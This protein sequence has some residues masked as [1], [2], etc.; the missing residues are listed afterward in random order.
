MVGRWRLEVS[1]TTPRGRGALPCIVWPMTPKPPGLLVRYL[2]QSRC[3]VFVGAGMSVGAGLPTWRALLLEVISELVSSMP[4]GDVHQA[5]LKKLVDQGKLLEV[6][7]FCKEQLGAAYHQF[8]TERLRGDTAKLPATHQELMHLPFSAW[9]TTNYDKLLERAYSEIKGGFPKT[10]THRDT[11][12][13]GRLLF[14]SGPFI[15]K[16]HGDIDRPETVV[17]TSRDY[18][19]IIHANP[20]FNE[21]FTGLLLTKALFFVG[22][23]LSD[24]DFRLLMDRQLTHFRGFVP[25]RFALMTDMGPVERDVLWRTARIQVIPYVNS[26]GRHEE[27]LH[28]L[29]ALNAAVKPEPAPTKA[30]PPPP[31]ASSFNTASPS[32]VQVHP[33]GPRPAAARAP[34]PQGAVGGGIIDRLW[35]SLSSSG[36][37]PAEEEGPVAFSAPMSEPRAQPAPGAPPAPAAVAQAAPVAPQPS[38][39]VPQQLFI[40]TVEGRLQLRLTREA[41]SPVA[42]GIAPT[43]LHEGLW[44]A[45][46][47]AV[48][49]G[50]KFHPALYPQVEKLFGEYL[51]R[52]V[53]EALAAP[54]SSQAPLVLRPA[55]GLE[56]F[57]WE[58]LP[59]QGR[60]LSLARKVV[61]APVGVSSQAR[62][63]PQ[64]RVTPR[65]LL[66]EGQLGR[67]GGGP[68]E[69]ERLARLYEASPELSCK[70]LA[71]EEATFGRIMGELDE[72]LP[73]LLHYSGDVGQVDGELHLRLPGSMHLSL[74]ALRSMLNRGQ[75]PFLVMNAPCSAFAPYAF[76]VHPGTEGYQRLLVPKSR[77]AIFEG[78]AGF[79]DLATQVGVGAFVGAFDQPSA[80]A[81]PF[82]MHA[83][84]RALLLFPAAEAVRHARKETREKFPEDSTALQFVLS[85]AGDLQL[86]ES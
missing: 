32:E 76:G 64:V 24:P 13:L 18:S 16:A 78:R 46:N 36:K 2:K 20:A 39:A 9:V 47:R 51:P 44:F 31:Q 6:A 34:S 5:E 27:V 80:E 21:V 26:S 59:V 37:S 33:A 49:E 30:N 45:M 85:G 61:R 17:L 54:G 83:L 81:G 1:L 70:V 11:D 41:S 66:V 43:K 23:S 62:G 28:F 29:R 74:G 65:I 35:E 19:E 40:E 53:L 77:A 72:A 75:L 55:P 10:L 58:L 69:V 4:E 73:D 7:D 82:F 25:E 15:L 50:G 68:G 52:E 63:R 56:R 38:S 67:G 8:L 86:L 57:P 48:E 12:T 79:M 14:D 3:V 84:H 60:P 42:Q 71:G 22:Y